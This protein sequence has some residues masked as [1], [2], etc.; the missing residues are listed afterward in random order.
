MARITREAETRVHEM[1]DVY[2]MD[3]VSP[4][5]IPPGVKKDG[6]SYRWVNTGIKGA[7]SYRVEECAAKGWTL[8][9]ADRAPGYCFD[10]LDRNP[11]FKK[12]ICY[13]DVVLMERPE[14]FCK[15]ATDAL[16][17][18]NDNKIKSLRGVSNDM[19][20]FARP[21]NSINSF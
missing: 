16:H 9:H 4:L 3:Y 20:S 1:R 17:R 15:K 2:D 19:G 13:K 7:E 18:L 21:L 6:Y 14:I 10:P 11:M 5:T 12:Y 8:V